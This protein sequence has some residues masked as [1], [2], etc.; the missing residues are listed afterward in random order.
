MFTGNNP[1]EPQESGLTPPSSGPVDFFKT[2]RTLILAVITGLVV[3]ALLSW[4]LI[5]YLGNLSDNQPVPIATTTTEVATST[6]PSYLPGDEA[7]TTEDILD[8]A[9]LSG[10]L[11]KYNF[12]DFFQDPGPTP[13][14]SFTDYSLPLN[15]KIDVLN[16]YDV[17]RRLDLDSALNELN[18]NGFAVINNPDARA[19]KDFYGAYDWLSTKGVPLLVT[20]DFLLYYHQNTVKRVFKDIEET[21]FY[22]NLHKISKIFYETARHR[23]E[24][25]LAEIGNINDP[26]LEGQ[27]LA[28]AYFAVTLKLL[29]PEPSQIDPDSKADNKFSTR[30]AANFSFTILPYLQSD[31]G[32]EVAL[33]RG[34]D[35]KTKSPV[36]RYERDYSEF[37]VPVEYRRTE[38]LRNFYLATRWLNS[39]F[40][41]VARDKNCPQCL[42]DKDDER[43]SLTAATFITKDFSNDQELKSRWALVYKLLSYSQGLRDDLTYRQY[44]EA[45]QHLFGADY[46][47]AALFALQ[48]KDGESNLEKLR[49]E[50]LGLNFNPSLGALNKATQKPQ[51]G[52]KLLSD[53]YWPNEYILGRLSG[54]AVGTFSGS[55]QERNNK[56]NLSVCRSS[57]ER[58]SGIGLDIVAL[59][60]DKVNLLDYWRL[61]AKYTKYPAQLSALE[62]DLKSWPVWHNSNYWSTLGAIRT[63]FSNNSGQMQAYAATNPWQERL[64]STAAG[65]WVDLQLPLADITP[66]SQASS[67]RLS[68]EV[69]IND[70]FYIEPNYDLVKKLLAD[71]EMLNGLFNAMGVNR[72]VPSVAIILKEE[73]VKLTQVADIIKKELDNT[74][75]SQSEQ[76]FINSFARQYKLGANPETRIALRTGNGSLIQET[77]VNL[78]T[79]V[80]ELN[81]QKYLA[82]GPVFLY[83]EMR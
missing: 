70:N 23:Y 38:K 51:L 34:A 41:L 80:Y 15:V 14:F 18:N 12:R 67:G 53:Y 11:E 29:E 30:E 78:M 28:T 83:N 63:V 59:L 56:K 32:K 3:V 25:R 44:D 72:Q 43:I 9:L 16:Y 74:A 76:D 31:A 71:N 35:G 65:A 27:R 48:N 82:V 17:S 24:N 26:I 77:G 7:T 8:Q 13:K 81:S 33:I 66:A 2:H 52:F 20:S 1:P 22:D 62:K 75:L 46:D 79:L 45:M 5:K 6:E 36:L 58:C 60:T 42:L 68:S 49:Q 37:S 50:L 10:A 73:N 19:I 4:L 47:P 55:E 21:V 69:V 64:V 54:A 40:P 39:N 57:S 61:N